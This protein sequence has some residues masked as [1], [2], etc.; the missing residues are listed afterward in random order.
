MNQ[1]FRPMQAG[2][3]PKPPQETPADPPMPPPTPRSGLPLYVLPILASVL[4]VAQQVTVALHALPQS[5]PVAIALIIATILTGSIPGIE[6]ILA[7]SQAHELRMAI[8][9]RQ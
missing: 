3:I 6:Q 2:A 1:T 5:T 8:V 7:Q 9:K 4:L